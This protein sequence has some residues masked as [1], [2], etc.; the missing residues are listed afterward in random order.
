MGIKSCPAGVKYSVNSVRG[1]SVKTIHM[2]KFLQLFFLLAFTGC[3]Y[4][5]KKPLDHSVYD[6]WQSIT[7][8]AISNDG[9]YAAYVISPQEGDG[10][11]VIQSGSKNYKKEIARGYSMT[12]S[13]DSRF[14]ICR[15]K[16]LFRDTRDARIKKKKA[17]ELPKDS[18]AIIALGTDSVQ[19]IAGVESSSQC[20]QKD[21]AILKAFL[22]LYYRRLL[23]H[24]A[25]YH[26]F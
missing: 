12:I 15:I 22:P 18:L 8:R 19:K 26:L 24:R 13:D 7:E 20:L 6:G 4:A 3:C 14:L 1:I 16:A 23:L 9:K 5:Q 17:D 2:R 25:S 21:R 11:L 10:V